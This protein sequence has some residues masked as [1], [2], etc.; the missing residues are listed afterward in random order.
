MCVGKHFSGVCVCVFV[1]V[2]IMYLSTYWD[3]VFVFLWVSYFKQNCVKVKSMKSKV[4][5]SL[6]FPWEVNFDPKRKITMIRKDISIIMNGSITILRNSKRNNDWCDIT[7]RQHPV[8][9]AGL[10]EI[11]VD[12]DLGEIKHFHQ[13]QPELDLVT[14]E[15]Y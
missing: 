13:F 8:M 7:T 9:G 2:R 10:S 15:F 4:C 14:I 12:V 3:S 5:K 6:N 11:F 1:Y